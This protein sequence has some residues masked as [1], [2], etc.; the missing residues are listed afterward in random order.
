MDL[1][2]FP[3]RFLVVHPYSNYL[4]VYVRKRGPCRS[5]GFSTELAIFQAS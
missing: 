1:T 3:L 4:I 5:S 2:E